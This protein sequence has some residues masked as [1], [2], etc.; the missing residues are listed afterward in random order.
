MMIDDTKSVVRIKEWFNR[1]K[2]D[3]CLLK[4]NLAVEDHQRV[5][6]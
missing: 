1:F 6:P 4:S 3:K 5:E 2:I